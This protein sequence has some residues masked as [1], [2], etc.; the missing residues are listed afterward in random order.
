M[1]SLPGR[2]P[3]AARDPTTRIFEAGTSAWSTPLSLVMQ[4][5]QD[6]SGRA[7]RNYQGHEWAQAINATLNPGSNTLQTLTI[8]SFTESPAGTYTIGWTTPSGAQY[9]RLKWA[10]SPIVDWIGYNPSTNTPIGTIT[11]TNWFAATDAT[12]LA[13]TPVAGM[14]TAVLSGLP[15]GLP[16]TDFSVKAFSPAG[17]NISPTSLPAGT[18]GVF[19]SQTL[20]NALCTTSTWSLSGSLPA[21]LSGCSS[22]SGTTCT[23]SGTPTMA[24]TNPFTISYSTASDPLSIMINGTASAGGSRMAGPTKQAGPGT[25]H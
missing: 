24:G 14:Q 22:G 8:T 10:T 4:V 25:G 18:V 1:A 21:G 5:M 2:R 3:R 17:C 6:V 13:P 11:N 9:L 12:P 15:A 19:Y 20:T 23:I 16:Q 7:A